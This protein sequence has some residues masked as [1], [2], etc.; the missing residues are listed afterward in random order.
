MN[1][2][3]WLNWVSQ[4]TFAA[5]LALQDMHSDFPLQRHALGIMHANK[6]HELGTN[7]CC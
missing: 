3:L 7:V 5:G 6:M 2:L 1:V 4:A